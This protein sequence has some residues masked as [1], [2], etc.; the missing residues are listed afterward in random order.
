[1]TL[2]TEQAFEEWKT[3]YPE[4]VDTI[5]TDTIEYSW[6]NDDDEWNSFLDAMMSQD[7]TYGGSVEH[8]MSTVV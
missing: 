4:L 6:E 3:M 1:M 5:H 2:L 7:M 8:C